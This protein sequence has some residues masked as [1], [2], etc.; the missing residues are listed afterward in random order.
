[1]A[2]QRESVREHLHAIVDRCVK[3]WPEIQ[4]Q[5]DQMG[6][7]YPS[8]STAIGGG[9]GSGSSPVEQAVITNAPDPANDAAEWVVLMSELYAVAK[10]LDNK[11][12]RLRVKTEKDWAEHRGRANT[13]EKCTECNEPAPIVKRLDGLPYHPAPC[14]QRAYRRTGR[15]RTKPDYTN[16]VSEND[17]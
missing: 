17:T 14:W 2:N 4:R 10:S 3:A 7:G 13:V 8:S 12:E 5:A 16:V 11:R 9:S 15:G 1:M 6:R